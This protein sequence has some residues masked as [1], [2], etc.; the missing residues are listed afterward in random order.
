MWTF[1]RTRAIGYPREL[2]R[3]PWAVL[4]TAGY[5]IASIWTGDIKPTKGAEV[6]D[7]GRL[8]GFLG[9]LPLFVA[10]TAVLSV[11][12]V[13]E[14]HKLLKRWSLDLPV[15]AVL[16]WW[17]LDA[18]G[19]FQTNPV[20]ETLGA[21]ADYF[22]IPAA[23]LYVVALALGMIRARAFPG[24]RKIFFAWLFADKRNSKKAKKKKSLA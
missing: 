24:L 4:K 3:L 9:G 10:R 5:A 21:I 6:R 14:A 16:G 1:V 23:A 18:A 12:T 19:A 15:Y 22:L 7:H 20:G 8:V 2:L 11:V 17:T 13:W